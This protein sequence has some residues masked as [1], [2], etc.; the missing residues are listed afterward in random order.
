MKKYNAVRYVMCMML[1]ESFI[2]SSVGPFLSFFLVPLPGLI[3]AILR[4][5][6]RIPIPQKCYLT[7][8][9]PRGQIPSQSIQCPNRAMP[10]NSIP[11]LHTHIYTCHAPTATDLPGSARSESRPLLQQKSSGLPARANSM[12]TKARPLRSHR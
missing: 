5:Q 12:S 2:H 3:H 8:S 9:M 11:C 10:S 4:H 7:Q 1:E 6:H